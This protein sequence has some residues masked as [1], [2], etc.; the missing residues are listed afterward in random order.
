MYLG[1]PYPSYYQITYARSDI[2][3]VIVLPLLVLRSIIVMPR[4]PTSPSIPSISHLTCPHDPS[5]SE[6]VSAAYTVPLS[7]VAYNT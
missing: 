3:S 7:A 1:S 4:I 6:L 5:F 2:L